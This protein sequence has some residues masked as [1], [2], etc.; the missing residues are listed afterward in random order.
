VAALAVSQS[1]VPFRSADGRPARLIILIV[2]P[3]RTQRGYV[4]T[5]AGIARLLNYEEVREAFLAAKSQDEVM[6]I[7]RDEEAKS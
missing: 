2:I 1:G 5:L 3:K 4:K 7:I 6:R